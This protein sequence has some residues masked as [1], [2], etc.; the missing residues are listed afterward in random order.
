M[1]CLILDWRSPHITA[2]KSKLSQT[3][4]KYY[5]GSSEASEANERVLSQPEN[6][7]VSKKT[8][9]KKASWVLAVITVLC[10]ALALGVGLYKGLATKKIVSTS[11]YVFPSWRR[12]ARLY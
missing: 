7:P 9:R 5:T 12:D 2:W 1:G 10:I 11:T 3:K 4:K 6:H 8:S